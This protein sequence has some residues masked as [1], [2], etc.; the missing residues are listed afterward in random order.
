MNKKSFT[1]F[2]ITFIA[3]MAAMVY[4]VTLFRFPLMGS[5]VHFANR[6]CTTPWRA[7]TSST[8]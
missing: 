6:R 1:V 2:N 4:V 5:K 7:M 8:C 3:M